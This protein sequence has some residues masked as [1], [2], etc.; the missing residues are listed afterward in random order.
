MRPGRGSTLECLVRAS[1][2]AGGGHCSSNRWCVGGD[3]KP[4][5][6]VHQRERREADPWA[7][8]EFKI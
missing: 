5:A 2:E 3:S 6:S 8:S 4:T 7:Q 1:P